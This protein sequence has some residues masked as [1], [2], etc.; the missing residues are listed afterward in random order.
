M[1]K[2]LVIDDDRDICFLMNKFLTK[3]GYE[4]HESYTAKKPWSYWSR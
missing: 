3:H 1:P 4:T 2:I